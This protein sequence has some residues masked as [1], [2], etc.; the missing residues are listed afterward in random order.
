MLSR[1]TRLRTAYCAMIAALLSHPVLVTAEPAA[2]T[3]PSDIQLAYI[4]KTSPLLEA[5]DQYLL[6]LPE[7]NV[8]ISVRKTWETGHASLYVNNREVMKFRSALGDLSP[9]GR[10]RQAA[11][12]LFQYLEAGK[13]IAA[14]KPVTKDGVTEIRMGEDLLVTL[15]ADT[16]KAASVPAPK[17][18]MMWANLLRKELGAAP[19]KDDVAKD[20]QGKDKFVST[21]R[22]QSGMASWYGPGFHG[23]RTASGRRFDMNG[24][25]AAHR[26]LPFGTTVRVKNHRTGKSCLVQITDRGPYSHGRIIDLSKGAAQA[27]G[28][29]G[30]GT[31]RVT[32]EVVKPQG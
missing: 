7:A 14:I 22:V 25:T 16:A 17:L 18:A 32:L 20:P 19:L 9:H 26:Y 28:M 31:A 1:K 6:D 10:A 13:D 11:Y 29:L 4:E 23:R 27:I 15:D 30:S 12:R 24:L 5:Q 21:G 3:P 8:A 2:P